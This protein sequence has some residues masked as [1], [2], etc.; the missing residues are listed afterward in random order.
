VIRFGVVLSV[1]LV[2]LGLLVGGVLTSSLLLVYLAIGVAA[3]AGVLLAIGV[4]IWR[5]EIFGAAPR[6]GRAEVAGLRSAD[7]AGSHEPEPESE[8]IRQLT[9]PPGDGADQDQVSSSA[10]AERSAQAETA[11]AE[12]AQ[13]ET[14]P[15]ETA[16][17]ETAPAETAPAETAPAETAPAETA[18]AETAPAETASQAASAQEPADVDQPASGTGSALDMRQAAASGPAGSADFATA[19]ETVYAGAAGQA[20]P[21]SDS[22]KNGD[23]PVV[24]VPGIARYHR[25]GCLLIRFLG[26]EDL[27]AMPRGTAEA[28]GCVPCKACKPESVPQEAVVG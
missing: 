5:E 18:P 13:A 17:A 25:S 27:E 22:A 8:P 20:G 23:V 14:A 26:P 24:V 9:P 16:P 12:T 11:P 19:G 10:A 21:G 15:A 3:A 6:T 7:V 1:V 4:V 2:A 28:N